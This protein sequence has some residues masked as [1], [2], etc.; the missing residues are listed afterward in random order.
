LRILIAML[1]TGTVA[2]ASRLPQPTLCLLD[3][4]WGVLVKMP[5]AR[6]RP[7]KTCPRA[8]LSISEPPSLRPLRGESAGMTAPA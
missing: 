3:K 4:W 5:W 2:D 8:R 6:A 1:K 7:L